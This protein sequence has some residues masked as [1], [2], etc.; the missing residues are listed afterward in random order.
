MDPVRISLKWWAPRFGIGEPPWSPQRISLHS[1]GIVFK[2]KRF[3][4]AQGYR[5]ATL[6]VWALRKTSGFFWLLSEPQV[7]RSEKGWSFEPV[8]S[9]ERSRWM[10]AW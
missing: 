8:P 2:K 3:F 1:S 6:R 4:W 10:K 7:F 9:W 5:R